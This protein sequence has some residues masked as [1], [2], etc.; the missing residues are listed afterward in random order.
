MHEWAEEMTELNGYSDDLPRVVMFS[1]I[2][3]EHLHNFT[4][5]S[6]S[7]SSSLRGCVFPLW[8]GIFLSGVSK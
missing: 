2:S 6:S 1:G 3:T 4:L 8:H 5:V 7:T